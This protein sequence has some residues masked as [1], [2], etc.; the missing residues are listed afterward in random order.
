MGWIQK[1]KE[2]LRSLFVKKTEKQDTL[3]SLAKR[4]LA[5]GPA[6]LQSKV[7]KFRCD[8]KY[9]VVKQVW[10]RIAQKKFELKNE[11]FCGKCS[12]TEIQTI[13]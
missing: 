12:T 4:V 3:D 2:W 13:G 10:V 1:A 7:E 11:V 9:A 6:D 8:H 5:L